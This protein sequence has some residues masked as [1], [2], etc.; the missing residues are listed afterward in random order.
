MEIDS[1]LSYLKNIVIELENVKK[2]QDKHKSEYETLLSK[3]NNVE[4]VL[5]EVRKAIIG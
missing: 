4:I 1:L 5:L 3:L 2:E